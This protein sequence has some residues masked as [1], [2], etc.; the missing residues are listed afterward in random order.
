MSNG[1][2]YY[3]AGRGGASSSVGSWLEAD[4]ITPTNFAGT[5]TWF[6]VRVNVDLTI[7]ESL[8]P[9]GGYATFDALK[10]VPALADATVLYAAVNP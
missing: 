6:C 3:V 4:P 7:I 10:V 2:Q 1:T 8:T 9:E 5:S